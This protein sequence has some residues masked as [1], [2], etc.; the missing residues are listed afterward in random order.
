M[1]DS[2]SHRGPDQKGTYSDK[3][4]MLGHQ[5]LNIID[6]SIKGK[7]PMS[8]EDKTI[9]VVFNGENQILI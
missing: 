7:Q 3:N 5:R 2:I 4:V 1:M 6:L 9:W 8:N